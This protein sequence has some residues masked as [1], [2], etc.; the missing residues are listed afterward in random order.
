MDKRAIRC[1]LSTVIFV[2]ILLFCFSQVDARGK[3]SRRLPPHE[4]GTVL[5]NQFSEANNVAPVVF[6]HWVHRSKHTCRLCHIDIGFA[7][8]AGATGV[9]EADNLEGRYCGVCHNGKEAFGWEEKNVMGKKEKNC[10]KC[11]AKYPI[12]MDKQIKKKFYKL[13]EEMPKGRFGNGID[14]VKAEQDGKLKPKDFIEG[15]SFPRSKMKHEQGEISLDA[16]LAGLQD[17]IFSHKKHAVWNGCELCHPDIFALKTGKTQFSMV[18]NFEGKF[19]GAC[20]GKIAFP[21]K[22]C[23]LCHAKPVK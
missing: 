12:G 17:I 1:G 14:W 22:D 20:H 15:V 19:C 3:L 6:R 16:K 9:T 8:E 7:M 2:F 21:N 13:A 5:M 23:G 18:E 11:H 10:D 4:Y